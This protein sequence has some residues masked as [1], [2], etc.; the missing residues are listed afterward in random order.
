VTPRPY[1]HP[2]GRAA[3][4]IS[5]RDAEPI[6]KVANAGHVEMLP[7]GPVQIMHNGLKV[8]YG[9]YYGDWMANVISGLRGHHEPQEEKVFH[10]LLRYCRPRSRIVELGA[11]WAYYTMWF[12]Q[13]VP[14]GSGLC[15]EPDPSHLDVAKA[16]LDLNGL[17]ADLEHAA[18][19][20]RDEPDISFRTEDGRTV[21]IRRLTVATL[22]EM[23][24]IPEIEVL[25]VDIQGG[26]A[27]VLES[28]GP[29][30]DLRKIRFVV[31]S[32]HHSSISGSTTTHAE[33][34]AVLRKHSA[35]IVCEHDVDESFSG[36]GLIAA[37][38]WEEDRLLP[39][40]EVSRCRRSDSLFATGY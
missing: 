10:E 15:V 13:A 34:L 26:E 17:V 35:R 3:L 11:F 29:L 24:A 39:E 21:S 18:I 40:I 32:T 6:P 7:D 9:G 19:G 5:C 12:M 23:H 38:M 27:A 14:F 33:C 16:N 4:T 20:P 8:V 1:D 25:H 30:F 22:M 28:C 36:D 31:C 2:L 37:A